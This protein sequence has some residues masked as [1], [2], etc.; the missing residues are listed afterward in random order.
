MGKKIAIIALITAACT[1]EDKARRTLEAEGYTHIKIGGWSQSCSNDDATCT[2]FEATSPG[3][4]RVKGAVGCGY[5]M[6]GCTVRI[7]P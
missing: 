4:R 2:K 5:V 6:K 1:S 7:D 3:K